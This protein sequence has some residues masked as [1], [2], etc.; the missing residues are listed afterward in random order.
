[1][2]DNYELN[3]ETLTPEYKADLDIDSD[4][5]RINYQP[6]L[7]KVMI[8]ENWMLSF[9]RVG[10]CQT[11]V[12]F[13][14]VPLFWDSV[15]DAISYIIGEYQ[16]NTKAIQKVTLDGH[17]LYEVGIAGPIIDL[18]WAHLFTKEEDR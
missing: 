1:M 6:N 18:E 14:F 4:D 13:S 15:A 9:E 11:L 12:D 16:T 10:E 5:W 3:I 17:T 7:G 8:E 2:S